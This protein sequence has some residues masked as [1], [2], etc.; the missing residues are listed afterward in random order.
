MNLSN[1]GIHIA[2]SKYPLGKEAEYFE[3]LKLLYNNYRDNIIKYLKLNTDT[4]AEDI[5]AAEKLYTPCKFHL[6]SHFDIAFISFVDNFKFPQ[7][8]FEPVT[9]NNENIKSVSYQILS[10]GIITTSNSQSP[11]FIFESNAEFIKIIQLKI[12]N[13]LLIG[14]G[15]ILFEECVKLVEGELIRSGVSK[16]LLINSFN[17]GEFTII[18]VN[19]T[20]NVLAKCLMRIRLLTIDKIENQVLNK[21][22]KKNSLYN[23]WAL[24][25]LTGAHLFSETFSYL[26]VNYDNY[27]KLNPKIHF[28]TT[29][30]WQIKPGHFPFFAKAMKNSPLD[31]D[32]KFT[33]AY[34]KNGKTDYLI[35][36]KKPKLLESNQELFKIL[37]KNKGSILSHIR[38]IKTKPLFSIDDDVIKE[39]NKVSKSAI[40]GPCD[41]TKY[42]AAYKILEPKEV[43]IYLRKLNV[44]RNTRKKINKI[45]YNYNLGIEDP[46]LFIYF[47][48]L[49][50]L[51]K[52]FIEDLK[53]LSNETENSILKGNFASELNSK[54][55]IPLKTVIIQKEL[56]NIYVNVFQEAL[57]D[58]I[59]NNY[60]YEDINEFSLDINSSL[61]NVV[62]SI[63]SIIKFYG[64]CFRD[65]KGNSIITTIN[66]NE[67]VSNKLAVNYNIE[68]ITNVPLIFATLI[69]EILNVQQ[70]Q[71]SIE[72]STNFKNLNIEFANALSQL[73]AGEINFLNEFLKAISFAY[74]EI[75]YKKY[76]LTFLKDTNLYIFWHWTYALQ[77]THLYSSIGYFDEHY[78]TR[79]LFR[80]ILIIKAVD[81]SKVEELSCPIPELRTYWDKYFNRILSIV[82]IIAETN[83]FK[84]MCK[85]LKNQTFSVLDN[86]SNKA[87]PHKEVIVISYN[88]VED[89]L[90]RLF[91]NSSIN[92]DLNHDDFYKEIKSQ[93]S[94]SME[95]FHSSESSFYRNLTYISFYNLKYIQ[96]KF[97]SKHNVL[98]RDYS[99]GKP[100]EHFLINNKKWYIDPFGGFFVNDF[101]ERKEN[102]KINNDMLYLIWHI[103]TLLKKE[104]FKIDLAN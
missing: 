55:Y 25:E 30:E 23:Q 80:L 104:N 40:E 29:I 58:R 68:H 43:A 50:R 87:A 35:F 90:S 48:D 38:K 71:Y 37:R 4:K 83:A 96:K 41:I 7:R 82:E 31:F 27:L 60:N 22:I 63:D 10:G 11:F 91:A 21:Q 98:R 1:L 18:C 76:Y 2:F 100:L 12:N 39:L 84:E 19:V 79:E 47:I 74:F 103:G 88:K 85:S 69:K 66:E 61:T 73:P 99:T 54:T 67:T 78:F 24:G 102:M 86:L 59:L 93:L 3:S 95:S 13:G 17:W 16:Y 26:G 46:I 49:Y 65:N 81:Q 34:F 36:E 9:K 92:S 45:I 70:L 56:I 20:P 57:E 97:D 75:D 6:F 72:N 5:V 33:K 62:S 51:L 8:V 89:F 42:L 44:S 77:C 53:H 64:A 101:D 28:N 94:V 32:T 14:N 15:S 52:Q